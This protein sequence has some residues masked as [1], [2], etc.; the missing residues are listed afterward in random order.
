MKVKLSYFGVNYKSKFG[1]NQQLTTHNQGKE[2]A[3][4]QHIQ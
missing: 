2:Q 3:I 4:S 1:S